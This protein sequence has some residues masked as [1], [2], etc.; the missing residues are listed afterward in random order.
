[1]K[2]LLYMEMAKT[3]AVSGLGKAVKNQKKALEKYNIDYTT[4]HKDRDYDI[5]HMNTWF[6]ASYIFTKKAKKRGKKIVYHA[7]STE[8]DFRNSFMLSNQLAPLV[9]KQLIRCYNLGD[10]IITPTLYSK[11]LLEGYGIKKPIE[12]ISNGLDVSFFEKNSK[13]GEKFRKDYKFSKDDK[14][15]L[16]VGL[17]L[18]RK[19][20][21]DFVELAKRFTNY[22]FIW[23]GF[24]PLYTVPKKVR[25]AVKTKMPNL[26]FPGHVSRDELKGAYSGSD[27][28]LYLTHEETEGIPILE[29]L[30]AKLKVLVRDI[31][32]YK[33]WIIEDKHVYKARDNDE[34]ESKIKAI[35]NGKY[36]N[37][38]EEGYK[39]AK[40]KDSNLVGKQL[41][42]L[43]KKLENTT[44][45]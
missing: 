26:F 14:V 9:K 44:K 18:E 21:T 6:P 1:M 28:F 2:I 30:A 16:S 38:S 39:I 45:K 3:F 7:H 22:K 15:I 41:I 36:S 24:T 34:F 13:L 37:L 5:L 33:E 17:Y 29:A 11:R 8:E 12:V 42:E 20:I 43:Y 35:M 25:K 31:P 27:L 10:I 23:F 4:D 40:E 19:G 32:I